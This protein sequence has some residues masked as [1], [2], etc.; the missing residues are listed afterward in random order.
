MFNLLHLLRGQLGRRTKVSVAQ[1]QG[2]GPNRISKIICHDQSISTEPLRYPLKY[3]THVCPNETTCKATVHPPHSNVKTKGLH[4]RILYLLYIN[5]QRCVVFL[6][7][8]SFNVRT[9][10]GGTYDWPTIYSRTPVQFLKYSTHVH[11]SRK[12]QSTVSSHR[13]RVLFGYN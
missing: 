13:I 7:C 2:Q 6:C 1:L 11:L 5:M 3:L 4:V 10:R 12:Q 8:P 9:I